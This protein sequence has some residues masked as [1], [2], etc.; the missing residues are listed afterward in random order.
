[1]NSLPLKIDATQY[2]FWAIDGGSRILGF[3]GQCQREGSYYNSNV[4]PIINILASLT[5]YHIMKRPLPHEVMEIEDRLK[6]CS[7]ISYWIIILQIWF[8][9]YALQNPLDAYK[10]IEMTQDH[11]SLARSAIEDLQ[12]VFKKQELSK[13]GEEL[14]FVNL[15]VINKI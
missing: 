10:K 11:L 8:C 3:L 4:G 12:E 15:D 2:K 6:M 7:H 14:N 1:M 13:I 5:N 9:A